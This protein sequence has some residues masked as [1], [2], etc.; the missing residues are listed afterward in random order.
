[1]AE[2]CRRSKQR[3]P[4]AEEIER[5]LDAPDVHTFVAE[6]QGE[7]AGFAYCHE[8]LRID[9]DTMI[10]LYELEVY[11]PF[12][13]RGIGR[14]LV[15]EAKRLAAG[16]RLFV[17]ADEGNEA[18]VRTYASAGGKPQSQVIFRFG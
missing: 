2:L 14:A 8:L 5:F 15:E 17:L 4:A 13:R 12:R 3:V 16:R 9:G 6:E 11:E 10:F 7:L 18:A 1:L